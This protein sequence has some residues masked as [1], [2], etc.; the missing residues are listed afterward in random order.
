MNIQSTSN[1]H[2]LWSSLGRF[3]NAG[4]SNAVSLRYNRSECAITQF[5]YNCATDTVLHTLRAYPAKCERMAKCR[6]IAFMHFLVARSLLD[7]IVHTHMT[8]NIEMHILNSHRG[9]EATTQT[10]NQDMTMISNAR[11]PAEHIY[12]LCGEYFRGVLESEFAD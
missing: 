4:K 11:W 2:T 7:A 6:N 8:L 5:L 12:T 10:T 3:L 1:A 9:D